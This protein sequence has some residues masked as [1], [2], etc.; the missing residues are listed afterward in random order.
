M[1]KLCYDSFKMFNAV[2]IHFCINHMNGRNDTFG[3]LSLQMGA[4]IHRTN[5]L[6]WQ[7]M[8]CIYI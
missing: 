7:C 5:G 2:K 4:V 3:I 8:L 6:V 1:N